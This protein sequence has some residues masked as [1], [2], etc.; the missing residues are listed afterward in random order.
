[1]VE[2]RV[3]WCLSIL[4]WVDTLHQVTPWDSPSGLKF[5]SVFIEVLHSNKKKTEKGSML[6]RQQETHTHVN[7]HVYIHSHTCTHSCTHMHIHEH[8]KPHMCTHTY[9]HIYTDGT[10]R[11]KMQVPD[12]ESSNHGCTEKRHWGSLQGQVSALPIPPRANEVQFKP[13]GW[14]RR[15]GVVLKPP[16]TPEQGSLVGKLDPKN[17]NCPT[18]CFRGARSGSC[19]KCQG[20][21]PS[22][23]FPLMKAISRIDRAPT[24]GMTVGST[25]Q[26]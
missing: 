13:Q 18:I 20:G 10:Q 4:Y 3:P 16:N 8:I 5:T 2:T 26:M 25:A 14:E 9:M 7:K 19:E 22:W 24:Y 12:G 15:D 11:T 21:S 17:Q 1:M 6:Y 23:T